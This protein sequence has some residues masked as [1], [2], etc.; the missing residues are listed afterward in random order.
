MPASVR[1]T[2]A[3]NEPDR[4]HDATL[5]DL[6]ESGAKI[7]SQKALGR[8]GELLHIKFELT[9]TGEVEE[10]SLLG[11]IMNSSERGASGIGAD[12]VVHFTGVRFRKLSRFQH[13]LLHAWVTNNILQ[14]ALR[15]QSPQ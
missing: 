14:E 8:A 5:V 6:S 15:S 12:A 7:G 11:D 13:V 3:V 9:I 2:D 4:F 10:L 1:H